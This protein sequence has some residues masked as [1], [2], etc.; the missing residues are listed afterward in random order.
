MTSTAVVA[1]DEDTKPADAQPSSSA[2]TVQLKE[3]EEQNQPLATPKSWS[4]F[5]SSTW[6]SSTS[7]VE[8]TS[9]TSIPST[10]PTEKPGESSLL[11]PA[12][13]G[14]TEEEEGLNS[15]KNSILLLSD[16]DRNKVFQAAES[17]DPE[18]IENARKTIDAAKASPAPSSAPAESLIQ[19]NEWLIARLWNKLWGTKPAVTPEVQMLVEEQK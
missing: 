7:P 2:I 11:S 16:E 12:L 15:L 17:D 14:P 13:S 1:M 6:F 8:E 10:A 4:L 9:D 5:S 19:Q 18:A 3:T